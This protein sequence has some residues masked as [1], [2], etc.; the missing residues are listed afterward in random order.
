MEVAI[1]QLPRLHRLRPGRLPTGAGQRGLDAR[2]EEPQH[3][4]DEQPHDQH[5]PEVGRGV[6]GET[7]DRT[8]TGHQ[9]ITSMHAVP[10]TGRCLT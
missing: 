9:T 8:N 1:D 5:D 10:A 2:G 4:R 6:A 3:Y 7:A